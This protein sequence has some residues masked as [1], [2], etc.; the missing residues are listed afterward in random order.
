MNI[1]NEGSASK[2]F[3][4]EQA[5]EKLSTLPPKAN[6]MIPDSEVGGSV[7]ITGFDLVDETWVDV[8]VDVV[9]FEHPGDKK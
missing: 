9:G 1:N 3:T 5:I 7:E 2:E 6:L 4:I 8:L